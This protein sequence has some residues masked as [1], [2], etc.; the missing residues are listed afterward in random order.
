MAKCNMHLTKMLDTHGKMY[1]ASDKN[2]RY[3]WQNITY[4]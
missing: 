4:I 1:H 3:T 2:V